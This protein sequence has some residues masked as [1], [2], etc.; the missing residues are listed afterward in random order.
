MSELKWEGRF[1]TVRQ[2][3]SWEY[4][5]RKGEIGAAVIVALDGEDII[6]VEQYRI[7]VGKCCLELPAGLVGDESAGESTAEAA[8]RELEEETGYRADAVEDLGL[9]YSSPGMTSESFTVVRATGLVRVGDGGGSPEEDITVHRVPLASV[10]GFLREKRAEGL[11]IDAKIL[12]LLDL[13]AL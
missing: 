5:E 1:L 2:Q 13:A 11:G 9:F 8:R 6:L 4:A 7:P 12:L 3:G 10:P